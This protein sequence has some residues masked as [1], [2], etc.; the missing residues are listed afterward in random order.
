MDLVARTGGDE[1]CILMPNTSVPDAISFAD[2]L[3]RAVAHY[4]LYVEEKP[5]SATSDSRN[6]VPQSSQTESV[7]PK[8]TP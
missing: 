4:P 6:D 7:Q 2:R 3:R 8:S 1:F 5:I